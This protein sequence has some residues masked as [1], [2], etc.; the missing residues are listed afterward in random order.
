VRRRLAGQFGLL[1]PILAWTVP[2]AAAAVYE[3]HR[4]LVVD[5]DSHL[6]TWAGR[7]LLS[8]HWNHAYAL[9]TVQAGPLQ[10]ALFGSVGRWHAALAL[11]LATGTALLVVGAARASGVK[12]PALLGGVG[13][14]AVV[15]G[16]VGNGAGGHPADAVLPLIWILAAAEARRGRTWSAGLLIGLSAGL[17]TWGILGVAVLALAPRLRDALLGTC[18]AGA[19][20]LA[21]FAPFMLGG[22]F[23]ML[24]F[25][26]HVSRPSPVSM[27]VP[28]GTPFGWQLRMVQALFAVG[29]GVAVARLLRRSP[30]ALWAAPLAIVVAR[31]LLDPLLLPYYLAGP[32][33]LILVGATLGAARFARVR[34]VSRES[35]A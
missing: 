25:E 33:V 35:F 24:S 13:L 20:A 23:H 8:S 27:L 1:G 32:E 31:L 34:S 9:S 6:F 18:L 5:G 10:L 2:A 12:N 14:L 16:L 4:N 28:E 30:H 29:G 15:T 19:I 17:E 11:V 7:T 26:W 21:L 3:L 22:H